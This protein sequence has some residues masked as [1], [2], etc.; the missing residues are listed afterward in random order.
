MPSTPLLALLAS[1]RYCAG[2]FHCQRVQH[3]QD[4]LHQPSER[5]LSLGL[6]E[7]TAQGTAF[8]P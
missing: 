5:L 4:V 1:S 3:Q 7:A 6:D 8:C 2:A